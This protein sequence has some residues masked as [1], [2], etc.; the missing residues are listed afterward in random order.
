MYA[1]QK[2]FPSPRQE[3][4][5]CCCTSSLHRAPS[6]AAIKTKGVGTPG[7]KAE[8]AGF[9]STNLQ[10]CP[11]LHSRKAYMYQAIPPR[12]CNF[13]SGSIPATHIPP[14]TPES[15][16]AILSRL[17]ERAISSNLEDQT[18]KVKQ[19]GETEEYALNE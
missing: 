14:T 13:W 9:C 19:S 18:P 11:T 2:V 3:E 1:E 10:G 17:G 5:E 12:I 6:A 4:G 8:S 16:E 7:S 15:T